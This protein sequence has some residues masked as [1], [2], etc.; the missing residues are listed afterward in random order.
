MPDMNWKT[1]LVVIFL[2]LGLLMQ[3]LKH[4]P[5][6]NSK[7][8]W[9]KGV[10]HSSHQS[11]PYSVKVAQG[12]QNL[13][14]QATRLS[15][16]QISREQLEKFVAANK[17][18]A[19]T[20]DHAPEKGAEVKDKKAKD[21]DKKKKLDK[22]DEINPKLDPKTGQPLPCKKKKK[23]EDKEEAKTE[24]PKEEPKKDKDDSRNSAIDQAVGGAVASGQLPGNPATDTDNAFDT[25]ENW[26]KRLLNFPDLVET[27]RFIDHYQKSLV[28]ADVFYK[29]VQQM[30]EDS[31]SDMKNLGVLCSG[32]TPSVISFQLLAG[33]TKSERSDSPVRLKAEGFLSNYTDLSRL[34]IVERVLK[35]PSSTY[36][37]VVA[38]QKLSTAANKL[39]KPVSSN[40]TDPST[41]G[42]T[43][44]PT[45][46]ANTSA[47]SVAKQQATLQK[48]VTYFQR[49][50]AI[51]QELSH[52]GDAN[53]VDQS[54]RTLAELQTLLANAGG[55]TQALDQPQAGT[56][57]SLSD[58]SNFDSAPQI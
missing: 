33:I 58:V 36:A 13:K 57:P 2:G 47:S 21:K 34:G 46:T 14:P 40:S 17:Q 29:I 8:P 37:T 6:V 43:T 25:L 53:V 48:N 18:T 50:V 1:W 42:S 49:F 27:N 56:G 51:L 9:A 52:S 32:L 16:S 3:C 44:A 26:Q 23:K 31:R 41:S 4:T 54:K 28:T 39:L 24:T 7:M 22:C 35:S 20:F 55:S 38:T 45:T 15:G 19:T 5:L 12:R 10:L 11:L 30:L